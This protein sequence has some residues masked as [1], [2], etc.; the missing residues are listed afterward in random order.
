MEK[1]IVTP[2]SNEAGCANVRMWPVYKT[3]EKNKNWPIAAINYLLK[4]VNIV[5][6]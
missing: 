6:C 5:K 1:K 4:F 2:T 3:E